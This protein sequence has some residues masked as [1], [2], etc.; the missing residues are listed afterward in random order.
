MHIPVYS[1]N[2][3]NLIYL[4]DNVKSMN[5]KTTERDTTASASG[6]DCEPEAI[7]SAVPLHYDNLSDVLSHSEPT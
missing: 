2:S 3:Y 5:P 4:L 7:S 6:Y 1:C